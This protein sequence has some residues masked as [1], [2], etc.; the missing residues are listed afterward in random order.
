[1]PVL[2]GLDPDEA[3]AEVRRLGLACTLTRCDDPRGAHA[4]SDV[5]VAARRLGGGVTL[6]VGSTLAL[7]GGSA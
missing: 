5:V 3:V 6:V 1:M 2:Y 7:P 4:G